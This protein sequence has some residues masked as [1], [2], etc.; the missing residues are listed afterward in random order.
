VA[1]IAPLHD[2]TQCTACGLCAAACPCGAISMQADGPLF[3][4]GE[5][6]DQGDRCAAAQHGFY[7]CEITC[8]EG[9]IQP[10]YTIESAS[11]RL[12]PL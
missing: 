1:C 11:M 4:C 2:T 10:A 8:P 12:K 3:R 5:R 9:A 6:C 7:P